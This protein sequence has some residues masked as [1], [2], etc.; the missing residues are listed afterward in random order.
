MGDIFR[1][2]FLGFIR[3]HV[4]YHASKGR[5]FGLEMIEELREHGYDLSPGTL[6]PILHALEKAGYLRSEQQVVAGKVRKYY[7]I[8]VAGRK[9]LR[10]LREKIRELTR[11]V[12]SDVPWAKRR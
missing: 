6:Y 12:L 3:V 4:L 11:E 5:I 10:E 9:A 7:R 8:T 2:T 1:D